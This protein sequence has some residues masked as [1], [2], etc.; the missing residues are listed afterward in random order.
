MQRPDGAHIQENV[1]HVDLRHDRR[2]FWP[3]K[4]FGGGIVVL[5][6]T[7]KDAMSSPQAENKW[8]AAARKEMDSLRHHK[9]YKLVPSTSLQGGRG[10][11]GGASGSL[12]VFKLEANNTYKVRL[13]VQG[14]AER[15]GLNCGRICAPYCRLQSIHMVVKITVERTGRFAAR[16]ANGVSQRRCRRR[17]LQ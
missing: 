6:N 1:A 7:L 3:G 17:S 15:P 13:V 4:L 14:W 2:P 16:S 10:G 9:V 11:W 5:P 12:W 8:K